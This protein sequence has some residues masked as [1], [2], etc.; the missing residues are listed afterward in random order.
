MFYKLKDQF[1]LRGWKRLS[2]GVVDLRN[3]GFKFLR[4]SQYN[5]LKK[6]LGMF[7]ESSPIFTDEDRQNFSVLF[8]QGLV[9]KNETISSIS[10]EQIYRKYDNRFVQQ[11]HWL[12]TGN[13]NARCK[14]CYMSAPHSRYGEFSHQV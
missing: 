12:L 13:C 5:T 1:A 2:M 10:P 9:E 8:E 4:G 14:H 7:D 6:C 11:V 3:G